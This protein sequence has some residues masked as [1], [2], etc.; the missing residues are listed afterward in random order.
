MDENPFRYNSKCLDDPAGFLFEMAHAG[1]ASRSMDRQAKAIVWLDF[2]YSLSPDLAFFQEQF[3]TLDQLLDLV[4]WQPQDGKSRQ[5]F[6]QVMDLARC[7]K[8][9]PEL[10]L[11]QAPDRTFC[12]IVSVFLVLVQRQRFKTLLQLIQCHR[13]FQRKRSDLGAHQTF[14]VRKPAQLLTEFICDHPYV[15]PFRDLQGQVTR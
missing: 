9:L 4:T 14:S 1:Q 8:L 15:S 6:G 12:R 3:L 13:L 11:N 2:R 5:G 10:V 7:R